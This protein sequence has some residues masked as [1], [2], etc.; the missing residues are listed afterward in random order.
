MTPALTLRTFSVETAMSHR[1]GI[2]HSDACFLPHFGPSFSQFAP[3][4]TVPSIVQLPSTCTLIIA[5]YAT[6]GPTILA[7]W[8]KLDIGIEG[9]SQMRNPHAI[10]ASKHEAV[11]FFYLTRP[12][13]HHPETLRV[14]LH[15][16][17]AI[18]LSTFVHASTPRSCPLYFAQC[19]WLGPP[20]SWPV[21]QRYNKPPLQHDCCLT[22]SARTSLGMRSGTRF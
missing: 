21:L 14:Q 7:P 4:S 15:A 5:I 8:Y 18:V 16:G 13:H 12:H 20:H 3:P 10:Y 1:F 19:A 6:P 22:N 11:V 2:A 17:P 9:K